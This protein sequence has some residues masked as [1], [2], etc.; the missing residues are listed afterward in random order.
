MA[1]TNTLESSCKLCRRENEK[2][3]LKGDRCF[4]SKCAI[5]KRNYVP[6]VHGIK[7]QP[8]L[9][10]YGQQL[11]SKQKAKRMYG[12]MERQFVKY[13]QKASSQEDSAIAL[14]RLLEMRFD[15]TVYRLGFAISRSQARQMISHGM[16][17]VN[18]KKM[19][20]P[21]YQVHI[22]D[23]ITIKENKTAKPLFKDLGEKLAQHNLKSWITL[24]AA[25]LEGK[26]VSLP[27]KNDLEDSVAANQI[28]EFYS[29]F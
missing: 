17:T 19:N 3:F 6:G 7:R 24:D 18:G 14:K 9:S 5:V 25:Q 27:H 29:R 13:Y 20:I 26:V 22:G 15:N 12:V 23:L 2:L 16:F 8:R 4:T 1:R 21:S 11:R 10:E 28:I